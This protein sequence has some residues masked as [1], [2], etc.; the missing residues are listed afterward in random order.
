MPTR[1]SC[2]VE[3]YIYGECTLP[4][5]QEFDGERRETDFLDSITPDEN[6]DDKVNSGGDN[7]EDHG[8]GDDDDD[9]DDSC[10]NNLVLGGIS[11][12]TLRTSVNM[13]LPVVYIQYGPPYHTT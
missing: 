6:G 8:V 5:C 10:S 13:S 3:E 2:S 11:T 4:T 12:F 9:D 1:E 7:D